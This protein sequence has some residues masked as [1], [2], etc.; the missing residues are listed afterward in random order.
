MPRARPAAWTTLADMERI[1]SWTGRFLA[2]PADGPISFTYG[3][4]RIAGIPAGWR[5]TRR[6]R[7][8][9]A[10]LVET[11]CEGHDPG[12]GL[13]VRVECV[14]Y[15]DYP[16]VEWTAWLSNDGAEPTPLIRDL[17]AL[18]A[19]FAGAA[20]V[21]HHC[22][23]DF[24]SADGYT[25]QETPLRA[26]DGMAFA[27]R[28]GRPCDGAFPYFRLV[29]PGAGLTMAVGWPGQWSASFTATAAPDGVDVQVGQE[30]THLRLRP[31]ERIRTP[32]MTVMAWVGDA[33]RS[34]NLWRRW[35]LAHVLPR[36]DGRPLGP[37][38]ACSC[39]D[40]G[41]EFT[42]ATE[43]NQLGFMDRFKRLGVDYDVWWI[44]AGWFPCKDERG[45]RHWVRTGTWEPD[46][47]RFPNGLRPI[48]DRA[49]QHGA[50][51]LLWFE[52][53]R[54]MRGSR[55][56]AEHPEWLLWADSGADE[57]DWRARNRLLD[58]GNPGARRWLTDHV[59]ALIRE[60]GVG[61]Y[62]QD[63]NIEPLP[64]WRAQET[65]DR[66]GLRENLYVQGYLRFW[67]DLLA[68]HP[69]LWIDSC[70]SGGRRNDLETMRRS[71]PL[72]YSDYGYGIHPVK[73]A[74]HHTL[75]AWIPYFKESTLSWDALG[76]DDDKW[77][78]RPNDPFSYHAAM[79][80]MLATAFDVRRDDVDHRTTRAMIALWRRAADLLLHGDYHPLT[81]FSRDPAAWV[82]W[83]FDRPETGAGLLQGIRH[84]ACPAETITVYPKGLCPEAV[85]A[86]ENPE[87]GGRT[88]VDG[89]TLRDR[90]FTFQL[91]PRSGAV[92]F[93]RE[94]AER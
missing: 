49:A 5:P 13:T 93:Y 35:Y 63:C 80:P 79:A 85:Y 52:P 19:R 65:A 57:N 9:D 90:G 56:D 73:L 54:V 75:Y 53:E 89:A 3:G 68:A 81:P 23:G 77:F 34:I 1:R 91:P 15:R 74:F 32:R 41:E 22:N 87:T 88:E 69:G 83:Q 60:N 71:V 86:F 36:P 59:S 61:V 40:G 21:L 17:R 66:R 44:D 27:P 25:P 45:E 92:W 12:T 76:P 94:L 64:Y 4:T 43:A 30:T 14:S 67:D 20:P 6:S 62:R 47:D 16:V 48:A 82:A 70:A 31:G 84:R 29:F 10:N 42:Q 51:L 78:D 37:K 55:L 38:L 46:R 2:A 28:G 58:L 50:A 72:H 24:Y 7:A 26:G 33:A 39:N 8:L 18:D 11:V